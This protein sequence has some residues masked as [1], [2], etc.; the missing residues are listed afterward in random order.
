MNSQATWLD[1]I[2]GARAGVSYLM[3]QVAKF[4]RLPARYQAIET[5]AITAKRKA[6]ERG[7]AVAATRLALAMQGLAKLRE[8]QIRT[9]TRLAEVLEG[10]RTAGLGI[11]PT[12][13]AVLAAKTA[14]EVSAL[15]KGT[16]TIEGAVYNDARQVLTTEELQALRV[17]AQE[18]AVPV[19]IGG[20]GKTGAIVL[21]GVV[22]A[23][24]LLGGRRR[25]VA[26]R[27]R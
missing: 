7:K 9:G 23:M 8:Q 12:A 20:I 14:A 16:D 18:G 4:Q 2:P 3:G 24:L 26:R 1:L 5:A 22:G 6:E 10:L 11:T 13:L 25:P 19:G 21:A 17:S 27:S 15:F